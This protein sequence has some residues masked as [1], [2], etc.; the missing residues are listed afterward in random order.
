MECA[1]WV[2]AFSDMSG[3]DWNSKGIC[4]NASWQK[5]HHAL[6]QYWLMQVKGHT[7]GLRMTDCDCA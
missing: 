1:Q 4:T 3:H 2:V 7:L 6:L 5:Y